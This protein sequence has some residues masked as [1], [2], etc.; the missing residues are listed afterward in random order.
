MIVGC[1]KISF[2]NSITPIRRKN[3]GFRGVSQTSDTFQ[4]TMTPEEIARKKLDSLFP[5]NEINK[6]YNQINRD[7]GITTPA[8]LNL[9]YDET[10][11]LGGGYTFNKNEIEMNLYDLM[12]C[13]KKIVGIKNGKKYPLVSPKEKLPLFINNEL[14]NQFVNM[15]NQKGSLGFE[16]LIVEDVT[17][18]EHK[19]F[20]IQ[21]IAH[22]CIHAKQ[23]QILRET[24]G[25]DDKTII[26]AWT[27]AK[28]KNKAEEQS[29]NTYAE[30]RYETTPWA[31]MKKPEV[32]YKKGSQMYQK[33]MIYLNAIQNYPPVTSPL[34]TVNPL[35][36]EA[37]DL[38]A[39]YV[40]THKF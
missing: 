27:H 35:E 34:Y 10:S 30:K 39:I 4:S 13:D 38:S 32:K 37:F 31:N 14:A 40:N 15:H 29:L 11:Q 20:I 2:I 26:K 19:K 18:Q 1:N 25:I 16:K 6:I 3:I 23:H 33:A 9:V 21:K 8:T 12:M 5:N 24:E 36:R 22:E 28:P 7:F 17:P